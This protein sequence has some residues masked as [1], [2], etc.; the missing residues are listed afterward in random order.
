MSK[1]DE[2]SPEQ[3]ELALQEVL[4]L[5]Q[6]HLRLT[7]FGGGDGQRGHDEQWREIIRQ[8]DEGI[9]WLRGEVAARDAMIAELRSQLA[10]RSQQS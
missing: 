7:G 2:D 4:A 8:R 1:A 6:E 9:P 5:L 10:G 3:R